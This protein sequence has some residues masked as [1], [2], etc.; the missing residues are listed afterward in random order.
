M[1][2]ATVFLNKINFTEVTE[3]LVYCDNF[4]GMIYVLVD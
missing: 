3:L 1:L 4:M 2:F